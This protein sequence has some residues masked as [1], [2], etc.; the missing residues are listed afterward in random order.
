MKNASFIKRLLV[1]VYDGLLLAGVQL[2]CFAPFY[3]IEVLLPN[4][5]TNT[6]FW[7]VV[8]GAYLLLVAFVFY[9]WFWTHGGQTLGM[10]AWRLYLINAN[11]KFISW[12]KSLVRYLSAIL[13]WGLAPAILYYVGFDRWY[14]AIGLGFTWMLLNPKRLAWH[15][16]LSQSQIVQQAKPVKAKQSA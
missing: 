2:V 11:G 7:G 12:K 15:D 10:K 3:L 16:F 9:A 4:S 13:S 6:E 5:I 1:I 8:K 14:L